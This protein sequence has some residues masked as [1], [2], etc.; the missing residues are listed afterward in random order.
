MRRRNWICGAVWLAIAVAIC[1]SSY[2]LGL[3]TFTAPGAGLFPFAIGAALGALSLWLIV[4]AVLERSPASE[5]PDPECRWEWYS[6]KNVLLGVATLVGATAI[7][8]TTGIFVTTLVLV[9]VFTKVIAKARWSLSVAV[10]VA[11][12]ASIHL[13]FIE[14][15]GMPLPKGPLGTLW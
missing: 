5:V 2:R 14:L 11:L 8:E 13:L 4:N 6:L 1:L 9:L 15:L 10:S 12:A 3:G 7:L